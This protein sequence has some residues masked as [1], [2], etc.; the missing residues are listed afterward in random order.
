MSAD[1]LMIE[2][3]VKHKVVL[4]EVFDAIFGHNGYSGIAF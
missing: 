4:M 2:R 3:I 1:S